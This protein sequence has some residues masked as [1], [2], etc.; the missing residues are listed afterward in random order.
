M[1][2]INYC[3]LIDLGFNGIK[4]TWS[5]MRCRNS[6]SLILERLDRCLANDLWVHLY[7]EATITHLPRTHS[8]HSPFLLNLGHTHSNQIKP[9]RVESIW[10]SHQDF[11][12]LIKESFLKCQ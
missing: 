4:Y 11:P 5:N 2:C 8:N 12:N 1:N 6:Q 3:N 9:F 10:L 7:P